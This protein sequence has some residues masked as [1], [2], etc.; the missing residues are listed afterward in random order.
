MWAIMGKVAYSTLMNTVNT[1][2]PPR[3][4]TINYN[5]KIKH[6]TPEEPTQ[7]LRFA[8]VFAIGFITNLFGDI[9]VR[10]QLGLC[11]VPG[12]R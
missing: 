7:V 1:T 3:V 10:F 4:T 5:T 9:C 8:D 2:A 11:G 12:T 6:K